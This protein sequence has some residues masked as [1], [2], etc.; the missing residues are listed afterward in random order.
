MSIGNGMTQ[1]K[2]V[3][4]MDERIAELEMKLNANEDQLDALNR[5]VYRQQQQID[6]LVEAMRSL[7]EQARNAQ[8]GEPL[9]L[10]E[11]IPPHY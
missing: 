5:T 11:E 2:R 3:K 4:Q 10:R 6:A 8:P 1:R 7:Q 9:N